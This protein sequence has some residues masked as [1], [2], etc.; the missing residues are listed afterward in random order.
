MDINEFEERIASGRGVDLD[1]RETA[2]EG[3]AIM[4]NLDKKPYKT[5]LPRLKKLLSEEPC[6]GGMRLYLRIGLIDWED[7]ENYGVVPGEDDITDLNCYLVLTLDRWRQ[8]ENILYSFNPVLFHWE[9]GV[10]TPIKR[11]DY[12]HTIELV[13]DGDRSGFI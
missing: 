13:K 10:I 6:E 4:L 11:E 12:V 1:M 8:L 9:S 7:A 5:S 3:R 2:G